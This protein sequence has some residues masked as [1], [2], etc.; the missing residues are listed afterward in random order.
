[1]TTPR[2]AVLDLETA[3]CADALSLTPRGGSGHRRGA[4]HRIVSAS[5]LTASET[6]AGFTDLDVRTFSADQL[7]EPEILS[8]VDLLLPEPDDPTARLVTY[9]GS[10][11]DLRMLRLR[12]AAFWMFDARRIA[13][14]TGSPAGVHFDLILSGFGASG[15]RWSLP[16][17]C[18]G[19]GFAM[20]TGLLA[21]SVDQLIGDDRWDAVV[22]HNMMDV[23][24][25]FLAYAHHRSME[26]GSILHAATAWQGVGRLLGGTRTVNAGLERIADHHMVDFARQ[27]LAALG[28]PA[29]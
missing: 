25:T 16:D 14:W 21:R 11:A 9:N 13:G 2:V 10:E 19:L 17:L 6:E 4:L 26:S 20:R 15:M 22:E 29:R 3:P 7:T 1:M 27:R 12:A 5:V 24:G 23:V 8:F 18:A 28:L